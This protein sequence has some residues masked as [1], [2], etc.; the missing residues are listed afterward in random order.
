MRLEK[1]TGRGLEH[2][3]R[4]P[5]SKILYFR[6]YT[7]KTGELF[8]SLR[9]KDVAKAKELRDE[10]LAAPA[11]PTVIHKYLALE[12]FDLWITRKEIA[13]VSK[14]TLTSIRATRAYLAPFL[15]TLLLEEL[16]SVWW[17]TKYIYE[18]RAKTHAKRKFFNDAKWITSFMKQMKEDGLII[19]APKFINPD[20]KSSVGRAFTDDEVASLIHGAQN[21]DLRLAILMGCTM[22]MRRLEIFSLRCDRVDIAKGVIRLRDED[23]KIRKARSFAISPAVLELLRKRCGPTDVW[24]FPSRTNKFQSL[25]KDGFKTAWTNLRKIT[26]VKGRFHDLRHTFLT[27]AFKA[28]GANAALI[29]HYAGLSLE[30]AQSTYLHLNE[31]DTRVVSGLVSY[32]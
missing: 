13:G 23:T 14:G 27:K 11:I 20:A 2:L 7:K 15:E 32:E 12:H 25:H 3:H 6:R 4:D 29:C 21:E 16:T 5:K 22:G 17:E 1:L 19:R 30:V 31:D 8:K 28:P 10:M 26:N 18:V 9:T 24:V